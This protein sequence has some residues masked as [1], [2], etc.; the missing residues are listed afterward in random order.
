[1]IEGTLPNGERW[2][3]VHELDENDRDRNLVY[4]L[5]DGSKHRVVIHAGFDNPA[6][7]ANIAD[8]LLAERRKLLRG[9]KAN[10]HSANL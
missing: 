4:L 10:G 6:L 7:R 1:M 8:A 5:P 2:V 9:E 3:I